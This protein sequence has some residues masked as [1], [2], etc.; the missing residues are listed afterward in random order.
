MKPSFTY[1]LHLFHVFILIIKLKTHNIDCCPIHHCRMAWHHPDFETALWIWYNRYCHR[2]F[3]HRRFCS[4]RILHFRSEIS[5]SF[6]SC[7]QLGLLLVCFLLFRSAFFLLF[8]SF[9]L[10][11]SS[12]SFL[13]SFNFSFSFI[14]QFLFSF[15]RYSSRDC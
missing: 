4:R 2:R 7:L 8:F 3:R 13:C 12:L 11:A 5:S 6:R 9:L 15:L 14:L 1:T 10:T